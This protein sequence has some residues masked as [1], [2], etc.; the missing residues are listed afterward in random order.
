MGT[1]KTEPLE[2]LIAPET[3][4]Q[5]KHLEDQL[6]AQ[7]LCSLTVITRQS[8]SDTV[9]ILQNAPFDIAACLDK[10]LHQVQSTLMTS[11]DT[12]RDTAEDDR[13]LALE[14]YLDIEDA[15][16]EEIEDDKTGVILNRNDPESA[17][18]GLDV[19]PLIDSAGA[20]TGGRSL[21]PRK[22]TKASL[23]SNVKD[24]PVSKPSKPTNLE[25]SEELLQSPLLAR[26]NLLYNV[27]YDVVICALCSSAVPLDRLPSHLDDRAL[28]K[29]TT[30]G[31]AL[32]GYHL[33]VDLVDQILDIYPDAVYD[34]ADLKALRP[35]VQQ[36]GPIAGLAVHHGH[37]CLDCTSNGDL[38]PYCCRTH[39]TAIA[40]SK[41]HRDDF[42][43]KAET[44]V[45]KKYVPKERRNF[46][47]RWRSTVVQ[48]FSA[49][50][51]VNLFFEVKHP[52]LFRLS[53]GQEDI[54]SLDSILDMHMHMLTGHDS[55]VKIEEEIRQIDPFY[56]ANGAWAFVEMH[57]PEDLLQMIEFPSNDGD[58]VLLLLK[59]VV[60]AWYLEECN[61][62]E[63]G[64]TAIRK[65]LVSCNM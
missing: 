54:Q 65:M 5:I 15:D 27:R 48:T 3:M 39:N 28:K 1:V 31:R 9:F 32:H 38:H 44:S 55:S 57:K 50:T 23:T 37:V 13:Y 19:K 26:Y 18:M 41:C 46:D 45:K 51:G 11:H 64:N 53:F 24:D 40:H 33:P 42:S 52:A 47:D 36:K 17:G 60:I 30:K 2:D 25:L 62:I 58:K 4:V 29:R 34:T 12:I 35:L 7:G 8:D 59:D 22:N 20:D 6:L 61:K 63:N 56:K 16:N 21:R 43:I 14:E 49:D 10:A